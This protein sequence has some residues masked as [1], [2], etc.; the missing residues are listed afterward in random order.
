MNDEADKIGPKGFAKEVNLN[1]EKETL[2]IYLVSKKAASLVHH[3][4]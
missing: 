2:M 1:T 3:R 4:P